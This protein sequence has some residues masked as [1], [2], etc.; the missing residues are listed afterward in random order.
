MSLP[1]QSNNQP[2]HS[3][4]KSSLRKTSGTGASSGRAASSNSP[5]P[6]PIT[7]FATEATQHHFLPHSP[8]NQNLEYDED[9]EALTYDDGSYQTALSPRIPFQPFFTLIQ[10][11]VTNEHY[12]PT[13]HYI[14]EDDDQDIITEAACRSIRQNADTPPVTSTTEGLTGQPQEQ[15]YISSQSQL[16]PSRPGV[17]EHYLVLDIHPTLI[18]ENRV[19]QRQSPQNLSSPSPSSVET[20]HALA[21]TYPYNVTTAQSLSADWQIIRTKIADAPTMNSE[22]PN[23]DEQNFMLQIEGRG[24][25]PDKILQR[26]ESETTELLIERFQSGLAEIRNLMVELDTGHDRDEGVLGGDMF[27]QGGLLPADYRPTGFGNAVLDE[28]D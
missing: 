21:R 11:T 6:G 15:E 4:S 2:S 20:A 22:Q 9:E 26:N 14:F 1:V 23:I 7:H 27:T 5:G 16:P 24:T 18:S 28:Q 10:N 17:R 19:S 13:V 8:P 3:P 12:H 25:S